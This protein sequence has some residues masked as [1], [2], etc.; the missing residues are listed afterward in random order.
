MTGSLA[1]LDPNTNRAVTCQF[2]GDSSTKLGHKHNSKYIYNLCSD[3]QP[4]ELTG[5]HTNIYVFK[6]LGPQNAAILSEL[7]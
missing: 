5:L 6:P 1:G 2:L 7:D 4:L 3:S